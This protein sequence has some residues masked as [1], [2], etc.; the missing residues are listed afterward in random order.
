[1]AA[2]L[3]EF[4]H[5][6]KIKICEFSKRCDLSPST[7]SGFLGGWLPMG[8]MSRNKIISGLRSQGCPEHQI[9]K[10]LTEIASQNRPPTLHDAHQM[11]LNLTRGSDQPN[12]SKT[13]GDLG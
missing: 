4:L 11:S 6:R 2:K 13:E 7:M 10:I 5:S 3:R 9:E 1:M 12:E 8:P